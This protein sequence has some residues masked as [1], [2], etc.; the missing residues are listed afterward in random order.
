MDTSFWLLL[1]MLEERQDRGMLSL[2]GKMLHGGE[3]KKIISGEW[4]MRKLSLGM[5]GLGCTL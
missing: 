2:V 3:T 1:W 5:T 4:K